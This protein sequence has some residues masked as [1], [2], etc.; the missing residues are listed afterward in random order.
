MIALGTTVRDR[1]TG[2]TGLAVAK[3]EYLN[4]CVQICVKAPL[5]KDGKMVDGE[6]I[7]ISQLEVVDEGIRIEAK[8]TG[9]SMRD[10]PSE[11]YNG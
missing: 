10:A 9:G 11:K 4:G 3:V 5:D 1:V 7:D 8:V 6:Y 2:F